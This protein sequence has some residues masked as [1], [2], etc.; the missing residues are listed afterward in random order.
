MLLLQLVA[1]S[2]TIQLEVTLD[3]NEPEAIDMDTNEDSPVDDEL[4]FLLRSY[5]CA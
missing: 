1:G 3:W 4:R 5:L 2:L